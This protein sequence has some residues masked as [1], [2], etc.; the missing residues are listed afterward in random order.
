MCQE[1]LSPGSVHLDI[2]RLCGSGDG[3]LPNSYRACSRTCQ[4]K[5]DGVVKK[6][7]KKMLAVVRQIRSS[8]LGTEITVR[9]AVYILEDKTANRFVEEGCGIVTSRQY[10]KATG[11]ADLVVSSSVDGTVQTV[12]ASGLRLVKMTMAPCGRSAAPSCS[13]TVRS[14]PRPSGATRARRRRLPRRSGALST[15]RRTLAS[16]SAGATRAYAAKRTCGDGWR[17][18]T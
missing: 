15:P 8:T 11:Q 3:Q 6:K 9:D 5:F 12:G 16:Y 4:A 18:L 14:P 2:T 17:P 7:T 10:N 13:S 1:I